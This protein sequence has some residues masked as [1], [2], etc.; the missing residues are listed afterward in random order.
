MEYLF[1]WLTVCSCARAQLG[2]DMMSKGKSMSVTCDVDDARPL[3]HLLT[4]YVNADPLNTFEIFQF[5]F[6]FHKAITQ[7]V[8]DTLGDGFALFYSN[9]VIY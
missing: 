3:S 4:Q 1:K 7:C 8:R 5:Y 2:A 9:R 6:P